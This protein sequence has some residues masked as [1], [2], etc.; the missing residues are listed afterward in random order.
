[1]TNQR[2]IDF[3]KFKVQEWLCRDNISADIVARKRY[4]DDPHI[5]IK[6]TPMRK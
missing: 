6:I 4:S 3:A 5:F 2:F 1:M